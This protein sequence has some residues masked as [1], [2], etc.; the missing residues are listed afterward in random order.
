MKNLFA[1]IAILL[2]AAGCA[3]TS[4]LDWEKAAP[5][6]RSSQ[7]NPVVYKLS[8]T[9]RGMFLFNCIPLWSGN[10]YG[11]NRHEYRLLQNTLS[12]PAM[13]EMLD[14]NLKQMGADRVEDVEISTSSSGAFSLW[15][16]W[17][18][19]MS[20]EAVAVKV[21]PNLEKTAP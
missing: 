20:A 10:V 5:G 18:R 17:R 9:N 11:P 14:K 2:L 7:G 3:H 21:V 19:N 16:V 6:Q 12:R 1:G 15:I 4:T 8:A 13:R